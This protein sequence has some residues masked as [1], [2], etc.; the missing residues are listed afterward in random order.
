MSYVLIKEDRTFLLFYLKYILFFSNIKTAK[1]KFYIVF[2]ENLTVIIKV[3]RKDSLGFKR[4]K[5]NFM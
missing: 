5:N 1:L 3:I 2:G 4:I